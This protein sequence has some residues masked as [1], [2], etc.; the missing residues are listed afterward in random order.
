MTDVLRI[1]NCSGFFGDRLSAAKEMVDGGNI[2]VLTGDW[3]AELT[4]IIL[5]RQMAKNPDAGYASTFIR[6]VEDVLGTCLDKGIKIVSNAGGLNPRGAASAIEGI[7][8]KLGLT[9]TV[10]YV[11][12]DDIL[13]RVPELI[14]SG[15]LT[16]L[17]SGKPVDLAGRTP[18]AA[19]AYLGGW[20]I[21]SCLS[22]GADVVVTGRVTDAAVVVGP[23]MW[24]FD[25]EYDDFDAIA[26]AIVAGHVIE[27]GGQ[28]TGGNFAFYDEVPG[29]E[30]IGF[31]IAEVRADG[32][33]VITKHPGTG[34]LV[35]V[36]TVKAQLLYE[37]GGPQ[38]AN[39]DATALLDT[40][41]LRQEAPDRVEISGVKGVAPPPGLKVSMAVRGGFR[42]Q[43]LLCLTGD[44][45]EGKAAIAEKTIWNM[46][47]GGRD[48]FERV[49]V[50]LLGRPAEDPATFGAATTL[51]RIAVADSD[52]KLVGRAFS[53][54]VIQTGLSTYPG[55]YA[56]SPP[57]G[58]TAYE[59]YIPAVVDAF[60][61]DTQGHVGDDVTEVGEIGRTFQR[62]LDP[63]SYDDQP[64][65][66]RVGSNTTRVPLGRIAGARSGDKGGNANLGIWARTPEAFEYLDGYLSTERL[67]ELI[68]GIDDLKVQRYRLPNLWAI[69][70]VIEGFLGDGV[71][72]SLRFDAQ[73]KGL[74]EYARSRHID[75]PTELL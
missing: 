25:W 20:S 34:G 73:A 74:G 18:L 49:E 67:R 71:S 8:Q 7:A 30:R 55:L 35:S 28:A 23:A 46:I 17:D 26:G 70:F 59:T 51:L 75:V 66:S 1:A 50:D 9:A 42:N 43:M 19:N 48:A 11:T 21:A 44:D 69:N 54:A 47:P 60:E 40:V 5:R 38:Y 31:P 29:I 45:P 36:D 52:E 33:S 15:K 10:G 24:A 41:H 62:E 72:S 58:A 6:Q 16:E 3:L 22:R 37:V 57:S 27:C 32:S 61:V 13:D 4:M 63:P 39:P 65:P 56:T 14:D 64:G 12:G 68:P 53:G 2:D